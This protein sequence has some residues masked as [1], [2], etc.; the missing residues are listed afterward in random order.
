MPRGVDEFV[1]NDGFEGG[2]PECFPNGGISVMY[3]GAQLPF[4]GELLTLPWEVYRHREP[5]GGSLRPPRR[6]ETLRTPFLLEKTLTLRS[7]SAALEIDERLTNLAAEEMDVMWGQHPTFGPP[8]LDATCRIDVPPCRASTERMEPWKDGQLQFG[9]SFDWPS[10]PL[11]DGGFRDLS[12]VP[13]PEA[14]TADLVFLHGFEEGWYGITSGRRKVGFGLR[15][16]PGVYPYLWF[17]HVWGGM[18]GYPWYGLNYD[19]A[20]EPWSSWPDAGLNRAIENGSALKV[21]P[22]QI[23]ETRLVAVAYDGTDRIS[24]ISETGEIVR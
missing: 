14:R 3:K 12:I 23:L 21:G 8:F 17:W 9:A 15:W 4:H 19:C 1:F 6:C 10:A 16:D 20:L 7:G 13:G 18:P 22:N 24:R 2:W 5:P 11:R